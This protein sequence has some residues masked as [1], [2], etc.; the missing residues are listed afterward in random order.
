MKIEHEQFGDAVLS[1]R[2]CSVAERVP[3]TNLARQGSA[4]LRRLMALLPVLCE[5]REE[6]GG[7]LVKKKEMDNLVCPDRGTMASTS[8]KHANFFIPFL[9]RI[10]HAMIA[11][12]IYLKEESEGRHLQN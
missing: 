10:E 4:H 3:V 2:V 6:R 1:V 9:N 7:G 8:Q 5:D 12:H 11:Q